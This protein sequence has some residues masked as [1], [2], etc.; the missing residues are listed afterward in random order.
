MDWEGEVRRLHGD[1]YSYGILSLEMFIGKRP[2]DE[3]FKD[4][5]SLHELAKMAIPSRVTEIVDPHLLLEERS[6]NLNN[7][8]NSYYERAKIQECLVSIVRIGVACSMESPGER[9][10]M[11]DVVKKLQALRDMF[12]G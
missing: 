3:M 8:N 4:G 11:I 6:A 2:T 1:V 5:L 10:E 9:M 12:V 7:A